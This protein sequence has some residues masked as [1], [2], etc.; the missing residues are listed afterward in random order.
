MMQ[1]VVPGC[2]PTSVGMLAQLRGCT[3]RDAGW[4]PR[5]TAPISPAGAVLA[6]PDGCSASPAETIDLLIFRSWDNSSPSVT[7]VRDL[8]RRTAPDGDERGWT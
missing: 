1:G 5:R 7:Q 4:V 8:H 3:R 2:F 6:I